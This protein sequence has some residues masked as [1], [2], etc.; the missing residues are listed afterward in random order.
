[1]TPTA[2]GNDGKVTPE[3]EAY[4]S[5][6]SDAM[7]REEELTKISEFSSPTKAD[8]KWLNSNKDFVKSLLFAAGRDSALHSTNQNANQALLKVT[9]ECLD[10]LESTFNVC[11]TSMHDV[12][13]LH[14][15]GRFV[16]YAHYLEAFICNLSVWGALPSGKAELILGG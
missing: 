16:D 6:E 3:V 9:Q 7:S 8:S 1:M 12:L 2:F 14:S 15:M 11:G 4:E 13:D 10:N 5:A